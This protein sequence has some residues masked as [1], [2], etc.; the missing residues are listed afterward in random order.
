MNL[1]LI[2]DFRIGLEFVI[3][4]HSKR[5]ITLF[6]APMLILSLAEFEFIDER[7]MD[8]WKVNWSIAE[9]KKNKI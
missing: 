3:Y 1:I 8:D 7:I 6:C 4:R 5:A 9:W 2:P